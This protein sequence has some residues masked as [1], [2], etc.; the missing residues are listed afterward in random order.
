MV[1]A[2]AL[3][4][5]AVGAP[6]GAGT[7]ALGAATPSQRAHATKALLRLSDL[8]AG[9][10]SSPAT[11]GGN[12]NFPG[13]AQLASCIG[14]P[15]KLIQSNPP[16]VNAP[17]FHSKDQTL[18]VDDNV[19]VFPST[20]YATAE[21]GAISN[22]KTA[23]C[24]STLMNGP[25]KAQIAAS[26]G[27]G[28][29]VGTISLT[30]AGSPRGTAAYDVGVPITTQGVVVHLA[31]VITYFIQGRYGQ[32]ITFYGYGTPF[33]AALERHLLSVAQARL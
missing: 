17:D 15:S 20:R 6:A 10:T 28:S 25:F 8:P 23:G 21:Y 33:P 4:A 27:N 32:N 12:N 3:G 19:S 11:N 24:M 5:V 14:V 26:A 7:R 31:L 30:R 18:E 1:A 22:A 2:L 13:A 9:W 29:S 16:Q